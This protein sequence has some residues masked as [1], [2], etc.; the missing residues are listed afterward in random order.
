MGNKSVREL[1][2]V[3]NTLGKRLENAGFKK[4]DQVYGKYLVMD[5]SRD[6]FEGWMKNTSNANS[7]QANDC[8]Q[9]LKEWN[10]NFM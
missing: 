1:P 6:R 3:G 10:N 7:K 2:G 5:Q 8:Y 4:S 9:G